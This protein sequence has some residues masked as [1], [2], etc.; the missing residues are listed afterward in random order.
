MSCDVSTISETDTNNISKLKVNIYIQDGPEGDFSNQIKV[1]LTDG[2]K[3]IINEKIKI[4]LNEKPLELFVKDELYYTKK[5]FYRTPKFQASDSY[6]FKIILP[7]STIYPLAFFKPLKKRDSTRFLIPKQ[8]S[9]NEDFTLEW[10][11]VNSKTT[12]EIWKLVHHKKNIR[13]HSGGRYAKST[14][15]NTINSKNG[16]YT[17]PRSYFEDSLSVADYLKVRINNQEN[18]LINPKLLYTSTIIYNYTIEETI[19]LKENK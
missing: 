13:E 3:Q 11:N 12:L 17:V 19:N 14:I 8:N 5:S 16:K 7:D 1:E 9:R 18:G 15:T 10:K 2:K 4:L 6:Y